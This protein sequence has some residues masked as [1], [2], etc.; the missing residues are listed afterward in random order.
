MDS[1]R[2]LAQKRALLKALQGYNRGSHNFSAIQNAIAGYI[3]TYKPGKRPLVPKTLV[4][5]GPKNVQNIQ[6][7]LKSH[8]VAYNAAP[9]GNRNL[10]GVQQTIVNYLE[11]LPAPPPPVAGTTKNG[12]SG[13]ARAAAAASAAFQKSFGKKTNSQKL[14]LLLTQPKAAQ[15]SNAAMKQ[16]AAIRNIL[17]KSTNINENLKKRARGYI[18]QL[19]VNKATANQ[20]SQI[21][22]NLAKTNKANN[23]RKLRERANSLPIYENRNRTAKQNIL[24][25]INSKLGVVEPELN[26]E[27]I[28]QEA[29]AARKN[30]QRLKNL[31]TKVNASRVRRQG[32]TAAQAKNH[33]LHRIN[34]I[35]KKLE[36]G[37]GEAPPP[38]PPRPPPRGANVGGPSNANKNAKYRYIAETIRAVK[39]PKNLNAQNGLI[40]KAF[41]NGTITANHVINLKDRLVKKREE[42]KGNGGGGSSLPPPLPP[43]PKGN[44]GGGSSLPPPLPPKPNFNQRIKA[45]NTP[46]ALNT[47]RSTISGS[48]LV[49]STTKQRLLTLLSKKR[50]FLVELAKKNWHGNASAHSKR[51]NASSPAGNALSDAT[52]E[53]LRQRRNDILFYQNYS[54]TLMNNSK[55]TPFK[56]DP[57]KLREYITELRKEIL[58]ANISTNTKAVL[59]NKLQ[60]LANR[61]PTRPPA[62][63]PPPVNMNMV[64]AGRYNAL[65][66]EPNPTNSKESLNRY[67]SELQT[68]FG[69]MSKPNQNKRKSAFNTRILNVGQLLQPNN[70][71]FLF[72]KELTKLP[73]QQPRRNN[74]AQ[75]T[76][77]PLPVLQPVASG[78]INT[79]FNRVYGTENAWKLS[80]NLGAYKNRLNQAYGR[81]S[82]NERQKKNS[83]GRSRAN[84][85]NA[86]AKEINAIL[87]S[88]PKPKPNQTPQQSW[89]NYLK[90]TGQGVVS[91]AKYY[92]GY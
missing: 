24:K 25:R 5:S 40:T 50:G 81:L 57:A 53:A 72:K 16:A 84:K 82:E 66:R 76:S 47:L 68:L 48:T 42:L 27:N 87:Q 88:K 41:R 77:L 4:R 58:N 36:T 62:A 61:L 90:Q 52:R 18:N 54:K 2:R 29:I 79:A 8:L 67:L 34:G 37:G 33:A 10:K 91:K 32:A 14:E 17:F 35:I 60:A 75:I 39:D 7:N 30:I 44:G 49:N 89:T 13:V 64:K 73:T 31:R 86:R 22:A 43:K 6:K 26:Y 21:L 51:L 83:R 45:A 70:P 3:N 9:A 20:Y 15:S 80:S 69:Q 65:F 46:N 11:G 59:G 74:T 12:G 56:N 85:Y 71:G 55:W 92:A 19:G 23:L 38:L 1:A 78:S 63:A 28:K